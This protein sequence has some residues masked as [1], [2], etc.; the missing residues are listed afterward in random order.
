MFLEA[1]HGDFVGPWLFVGW[2]F[3]YRI[4]AKGKDR[5]RKR[6][7]LYELVSGDAVG[8]PSV[9]IAAT[10]PICIAV[11]LSRLLAQQFQRIH[12]AVGG[13]FDGACHTTP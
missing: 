5:I 13:W 3:G 7:P 12:H 4:A 11:H 9:L 2:L 8:C 6:G 10:K 1:I